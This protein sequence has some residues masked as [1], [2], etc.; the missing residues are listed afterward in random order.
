MIAITSNGDLLISGIPVVKTGLDFNL[1]TKVHSKVVRISLA[2][3]GD[4]YFG[5]GSGQTTKPIVENVLMDVTGKLN[6]T[7]TS[8]EVSYD[9]SDWLFSTSWRASGLTRCKL[10]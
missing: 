1:D 4:K 8:V 2:Q 7:T 5:S 6:A 9:G 10:S 3:L